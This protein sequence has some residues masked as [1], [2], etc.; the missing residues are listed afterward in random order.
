MTPPASGTM[1][2]SPVRL[3]HRY[4][5]AVR[6]R[7]RRRPASRAV[8]D[9]PRRISVAAPG[10]V[11]ETCTAI[12]NGSMKTLSPSL[13]GNGSLGCS[14]L[15]LTTTPLPLS[16]SSRKNVP[17][18]ARTRACRPD[19][20]ASGSTQSLPALRPIEPPAVVKIARLA[21]PST[22][23]S[24][25]VTSRMRNIRFARARAVT[26]LSALSGSRERSCRRARSCRP[27]APPACWRSTR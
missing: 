22:A 6:L 16:L 21:A 23:A 18:M 27:S 8:A 10:L 5:V 3:G 20:C 19:T 2:P 26:L 9:W 24:R 11:M 17:P 12:S 15:P 1:S 7:E 14:R 25:P 13:S 4:V